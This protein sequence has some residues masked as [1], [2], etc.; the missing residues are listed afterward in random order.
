MAEIYKVE[1]IETLSRTENITANS[2]E[3]AISKARELYFIGDIVLGAEDYAGGAVKA[4]NP[5][6]GEEQIS[7][8]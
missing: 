6:S 2:L 8:L 1:W 3:E 5:C 4:V 7:Y